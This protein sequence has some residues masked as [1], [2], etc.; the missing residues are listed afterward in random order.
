MSTIGADFTFEGS[1][2]PKNFRFK[3]FTLAHVPKGLKQHVTRRFTG[4]DP[5]AAF[6]KLQNFRLKHAD[7]DLTYYSS[8]LDDMIS[9]NSGYEI[10]RDNAGVA[11]LAKSYL[12]FRIPKG[13]KL[14]TIL[15]GFTKKG[16]E[17]KVFERKNPKFSRGFLSWDVD[18][19]K[20]V[21]PVSVLLLGRVTRLSDEKAAQ[22][23]AIVAWVCHDFVP[24]SGPG[25][26]Y[27]VECAKR[28]MLE[29]AQEK[30]GYWVKA[31]RWAH[32]YGH[33]FTEKLP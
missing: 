29:F 16:P 30:C 7:N 25:C 24:P 31:Y 1:E 6:E 26:R 8:S 11:R 33:N 15:G 22:A 18:S 23:G 9:S 32:P 17:I 13:Q 5:V 20:Y 19:G 28:W 21:E 10:Y 4:T 27:R 14:V 12:H 2:C 3:A